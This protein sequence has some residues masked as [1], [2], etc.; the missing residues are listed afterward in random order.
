[1][2]HINHDSLLKMVKDGMVTGVEVD[3]NSKPDF[4]ETCIKAKVDR[5]P[6]PKKSKT[7][8]TKYGEKV[9]ADLWGPAKVTS[10]GG[11]RHYFLFKDLSSW[12]EK[13]HFLKVKSEAYSVYKKYEA[14]ALVQCGA[15]IKIF[16][17]DRA[18][19]L[20]S[21]EFNEHL[22]NAGTVQHLTVHDSPASNSIVE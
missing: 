20:T 4:C 19:E 7:V 14:W 1:M 6:F 5:K 18:G 13:V 17:C 21:K 10:L 3:L 8:Y 2:G 9:V 15:R 16:G 11:N 12:E 22:Q